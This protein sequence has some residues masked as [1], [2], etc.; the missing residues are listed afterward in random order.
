MPPS[1]LAKVHRQLDEYL[2]KSWVCLSTSPHGAPIL[3]VYKKD[4]GLHMSI[5][6]QELNKKIKLDYYPLP[7]I[8]NLLNKLNFAYCLSSIDLIYGCH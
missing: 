3:F 1:E 6:Y 7:W 4:G 2:S 8:D 5:D